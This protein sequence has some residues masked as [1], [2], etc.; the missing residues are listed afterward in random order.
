MQLLFV[1]RDNGSISDCGKMYFLN[2]RALFAL[3]FVKFVTSDNHCKNIMIFLLDAMNTNIDQVFIN[4][5]RNFLY[6]CRTIFFAGLDISLYICCIRITFSIF[7]QL[8]KAV[9][10]TLSNARTCFCVSH[11]YQVTQPL[12]IQCIVCH[13]CWFLY[14]N[15]CVLCYCFKCFKIC[16]WCQ[17]SLILPCLM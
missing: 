16:N 7:E 15:M 5:N 1:I 11:F 9:S 14:S 2:A 3:S 4:A 12:N 13:T 10:V 6:L 17:K 8:N